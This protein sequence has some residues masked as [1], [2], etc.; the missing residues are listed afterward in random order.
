MSEL[1]ERPNNDPNFPTDSHYML[2]GKFS[3]KIVITSHPENV[4]QTR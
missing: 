2:H 4:S 1:L 3:Q